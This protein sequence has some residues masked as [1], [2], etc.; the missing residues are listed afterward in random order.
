[1]IRVM[2]ADSN[3]LRQLQASVLSLS[4]VQSKRP[5][6]SIRLRLC[7]TKPNANG[8]AVSEAFIDKIVN[9]KNAHLALPL[10]ADVQKINRG[11]YRD[12]L[13]H[14]FDPETQTFLSTQIGGFIDFEKVNDEYGVSLIGEAKVYKRN[15]KVTEA[16]L[17]LYQENNLSFSFEIIAG[18][19][20]IEDGIMTVGDSEKNELIAM[21]LVSRPAYDEAVALSLVAEKSE[22]ND[23]RYA[24]A[25]EHAHINLDGVKIAEANLQTIE[26]WIYD[27]V[28]KYIHEKYDL[29]WFRFYHIGADSAILYRED[30]GHLYRVDYVVREQ[31]VF[32]SD[33]YQV[34]TVRV[35]ENAGITQESEEQEVKDI[36]VNKVEAVETVETV[37]TVEVAEVETPEVEVEVAET[38]ET[39]EQAAQE[40]AVVASV[41]ELEAKIAEQAARIVELEEIEAKWLSAQEAEKQAAIASKRNKMLDYA[42]T[43]GLNTESEVV[44]SALESLDYERLMTLVLEAGSDAEDDEPTVT[45]AETV[46]N[47]LVEDMKLSGHWLFEKN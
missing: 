39:T 26:M 43:A 33:M 10:V 14:M 29:F 3:N 27:A 7:S 2:D 40:E 11:D 35:S 32:V 46:V 20:T 6:I 44:A 38:V 34:E 17:N 28:Y 30:L 47:P 21:A 45:I 16:L 42:K 15:K 12:G 1:M 13:G 41:E 18:A 31:D 22:D 19:V 9:D 25:M 36:D 8:E 37:E 23:K 5:F 4:E 24:T